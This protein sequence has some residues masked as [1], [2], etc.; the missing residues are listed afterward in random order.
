MLG[1]YDSWLVA[2]SIAVACI[3]S[4]VALD[5]ASRVA[6]A[7][8]RRSAAAW[9]TGGA[10]SMGL[11]IW[12]MHFIGM[13]AFALPVPVSYDIALTALSLLM[14]ILVSGFALTVASRGEP[15][16]WRVL[17]A[18]ALMGAGISA[19]HY[20]GMAGMRMDPPI[21]YAPPAFILSVLIAVAASVAA[22]AIALH[23]RT[24]SIVAAFR[25]RLAGASVMGC[26]IAGMHYTGMAA[27]RF[28]P[29]SICKA[30][31]QQ[32]NT[33]WL[34]GAIGA[35][36]FLFLG[37]T[38]LLSALDERL[39][40]RAARHAESLRVAN[41]ALEAR[42]AEL[43]RAN[44]LLE[45]Q[46][47]EREGVQEHLRLLARARKVTADCNRIV[48]HASDELQLLTASCKVFV[49]AGGYKMAWVGMA[50]EDEAQTIEPVA[51]S[52]DDNAEY[53]GLVRPT[54]GDNPRGQGPTAR[55]FRSGIAQMAQ[56][57][58]GNP[59]I[60]FWR[61]EAL[62]R[63]YES[64]AALPLVFEGKVLAVV[65]L[66]SAQPDSF[67]HDELDLLREAAQDIAYGLNSLR[68]RAAREHAEAEL[69]RLYAELETR[70]A[71]RT[72]QLTE[73]NAELESFSYSVSHDLRAP[74]RHVAGFSSLLLAR[75]GEFDADMATQLRAIARAATKME[76]L[77]NDLLA[78]SRTNR[79]ELAIMNVD[80]APLVRDLRLELEHGAPGRNIDWRIG[81]LG[82][83]RADPRLLRVAL[84][85]L[86]GNAIKFTQGRDPAVIEVSSDQGAEGE[87]VLRVR[88]NGAGFDMRYAGKLFGVFQRMHREDEFEG[89]GVGLA[90]VQRVVRR[91]GGRIWAE[92]EEGKGA[93]FHVA[94]REAAP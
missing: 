59:E 49:A 51:S 64:L 57:I 13:L 67:S 82:A 76:A 19:M 20:T 92:A 10:L 41:L 5:L 39:A 15:G 3:A 62:A 77:I 80:L 35:S 68:V 38:L 50:R 45:Q 58:R 42:S 24:G 73:A 18:G 91:V 11:G 94:L 9:L 47:A 17:R 7:R 63:G 66:Y 72:A 79:A 65:V 54:W 88:D 78:L 12:A 6:A 28:A 4:Y 23:L 1:S 56:R 36:A 14:A 29:G 37:I 71:E 85:N 25:R 8:A 75:A 52:G 86:L 21:N 60:M 22:L 74:L 81:S 89:T 46:A 43:S 53:L 34:A 26:A 48:A 30:G 16:L 90:I 70:V 55:A 83:V 40:S 32:I 87:V 93:T 44:Q 69:Q 84:T 31:A 61:D 33:L 2:L 27:A